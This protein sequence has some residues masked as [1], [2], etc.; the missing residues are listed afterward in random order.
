MS[1]IYSTGDVSIFAGIGG[2]Q[3]SKS[4]APIG[5]GREAPVIEQIEYFRPVKNDLSGGASGPPAT[6]KYLG[7]DARIT[8]ALSRFSM[9]NVRA[10]ISRPNPFGGLRGQQVYGDRGSLVVEEN[11]TWPLWLK[12]NKAGNP[13]YP[14]MPAGYR[15]GY[16]ELEGP[17]RHAFGIE[18]EYE[19]ALVIYAYGVFLPTGVQGGAGWFCYD[20]DMSAVAALTAF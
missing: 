18:P 7:F 19:I 2:S 20:S 11:L 14:D 16:C 6:K 17:D 1:Q 5:W 4:P 12:F 3:A 8:V 15:F 10:L 13:A 9:T